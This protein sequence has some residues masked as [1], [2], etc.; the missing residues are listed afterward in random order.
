M[1]KGIDVSHYQAGIDWKAVAADG[2]KFAYLK[3]TD[4]LNADPTFQGFRQAAKDV[5]L[6]VGGYHFFRFDLDPILQAQKLIKTMGEVQPG[7]LPPCVDVEWDRQSKKYGEGTV[8]DSAAL[9]AVSHFVAAFHTNGITLMVY[10]N[11]YFWPDDSRILEKEW[12]EFPLWIPNYHAKDITQ[13]KIPKPWTA[14]TFWQ[15][16]ES[17]K[18]YGVD[19]VDGNYFMGTEEELKAIAGVSQ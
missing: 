18:G 7:E 14:A 15:Y 4:G 1:I 11:A 17:I 19:K 3:C 10:T 13:V 12:A 9:Q 6:L 8:M 5:G 16:S 2:N